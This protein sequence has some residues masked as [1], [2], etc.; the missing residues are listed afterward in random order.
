MGLKEKRDLKRKAAKG[1][2]RAAEE[3]S[4]VEKHVLYELRRAGYDVVFH[5]NMLIPRQSMQIDLFIPELKTVIEVDGPSHYKPIWGEEA[6][7]KMQQRDL[8]KNGLVLQYYNM[9]RLQTFCRRITNI[10]L[11]KTFSRLLPSLRYI[12]KYIQ[13]TNELLPM[14]KRLIILEEPRHIP[15]IHD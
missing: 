7:A 5:S 2:R 11:R 10:Y 15:V 3:G 8:I 14:E 9:I 13:N 12:Q 1:V 4:H 6:L